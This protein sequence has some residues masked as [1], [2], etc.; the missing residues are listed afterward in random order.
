MT[1]CF[2]MRTTVAAALIAGV[3]AA[4]M[5]PRTL[6]AATTP[7]PKAAVLYALPNGSEETPANNSPA[8][9]FGRL[10]LTADRKQLLYEVHVSGLSGDPTA[11]HLHMAP[12][13]QS[14]NILIGLDTPTNGQ[15]VGCVSGLKSTDVAALLD[16]NQV[17]YLNIHTK[18]FGNGEIRGQVVP[19]P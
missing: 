1:R 6:R 14:G 3:A 13:G 7:P 5:A 10:V 16:P 19:A 2:W 12:R 4:V 17:L 8:T 15:A 9:A 11:M 18:N